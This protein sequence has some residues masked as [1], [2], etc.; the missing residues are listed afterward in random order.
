M[1]Q[2]IDRLQ[3]AAM[4]QL[5][6]QSVEWYTLKSLETARQV[7]HRMTTSVPILQFLGLAVVHIAVK[8]GAR[9]LSAFAK[10]G[11]GAHSPIDSAAVEV[12]GLVGVFQGEGVNVLRHAYASE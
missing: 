10:N 7:I 3:N 1:R 8:P 11:C 9:L 5:K 12:D 2:P 6:N 4:L